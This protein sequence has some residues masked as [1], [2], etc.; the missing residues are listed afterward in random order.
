MTENPIAS[1]QA[2][3]PPRPLGP[4]KGA[5]LAGAFVLLA[6]IAVLGLAAI[7]FLLWFL[8]FLPGV[9]IVGVLTMA[10]PFLLCMYFGKSSWLIGAAWGAVM[11]FVVAPSVFYFKVRGYI[12]AGNLVKKEQIILAVLY[13]LL[14]MILAGLGEWAATK[15]GSQKLL[16]KPYQSIALVLVLCI[17]LSI[18]TPFVRDAMAT[19]PPNRYVDK[20]YGF[21]VTIPGGWT[22]P[23]VNLVPP[24]E[25]NLTDGVKSISS[26]NIKFNLQSPPSG[27]I[28]FGVTVFKNV[29][30]TNISVSS[31]KDENVLFEQLLLSLKKNTTPET[32]VDYGDFPAEPVAS[33]LKVGRVPAVSLTFTRPSDSNNRKVDV[34]VLNGP[35]LYRIRF[36]FA[37]YWGR[38]TG[39]SSEGGADKIASDVEKQILDSFKLLKTASNS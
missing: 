6:V 5:F 29:P 15:R 22:E 23:F 24:T 34:Y 18:A 39:L 12:W 10:A 8:G 3:E 27:S 20:K 7:G 21:E 17:L 11:I 13:F 16:A 31:D 4:F 38:G 1:E 9:Y 35:Y 19:S 14:S 25:R 26:D 28:S 2:I 30:F 33:Y 32:I 36:H 37:I